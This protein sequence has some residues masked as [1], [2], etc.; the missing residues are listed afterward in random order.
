MLEW[1]G[2][3]FTYVFV[4]LVILALL[5]FLVQKTIFSSLQSVENRHVFITG[6][7]SGIGLALAQTYAKH[8]AKVSIVARSRPSLEAAAKTL[9]SDRVFFE[10]CDAT[11]ATQVEQVIQS[12]V[13][14]LGQIDVL[15]C[16]AGN[17]HLDY[18]EYQN[19]D[20]F[21]R[22]MDLN[23]FGCLNPIMSV[24]P[25]M[26]A[27]KSGKIVLIGSAMSLLG[28]TGN[29]SYAPTK[30][31]LRG[32]ADCL[33]NE[34]L[35]YNIQVHI[36]YPP[37]TKTPGYAKELTMRPKEIASVSPESD[38]FSAQV[39]AERIYQDVQSGRYHV[40]SPDLIQ[41][42]LISL[43]T[44][45][46]PSPNVFFDVLVTPL[47]VLIAQGYNLYLDYLSKS[48][49]APASVSKKAQ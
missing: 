41:D 45:V 8:G 48:I 43:K 14:S 42:L 13:K 29:S 25:A 36:A 16:C 40:R 6:G 33:R 21:K 47:V 20:V 10:S 27:R 39:V 46:S 49:G 15:I 4:S 32:L 28:F 44:G 3:F 31:A 19:L 23:F 38:A 11:D 30:W 5:V 7:S 2:V 18:F 24:F 35:K 12:S 22:T 34:F 1:I 26:K 9:S 37:D 17:A